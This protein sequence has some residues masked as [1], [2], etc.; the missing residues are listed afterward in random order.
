MMKVEIRVGQI[1][2]DND[3]RM[4]GRQGTV[5]EID[6]VK[7]K[8]LINW[9]R[10]T[11]VSFKRL[12][13]ISQ[14]RMVSDPMTPASLKPFRID[15]ELDGLVGEQ[16][17]FEGSFTLLIWAVDVDDAEKLMHKFAKDNG[18]LLSDPED[19]S[20][21]IHDVKIERGV[22]IWSGIMTSNCK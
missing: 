1:W 6:E 2:K 15:V 21:Q 7:E 4:R 18:K 17:S 12:R 9:G 3:T 20:Y 16:R 5:V 11:W 10:K 19:C 22:D 14:Y 8:A 13:R